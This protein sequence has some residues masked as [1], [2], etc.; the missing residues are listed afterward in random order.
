MEGVNPKKDLFLLLCPIRMGSAIGRNAK[1]G[2]K[3][4]CIFTYGKVMRW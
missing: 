4:M 1:E 2:E 3:D